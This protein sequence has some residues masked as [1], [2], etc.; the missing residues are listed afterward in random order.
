MKFLI[1][2]RHSYAASNNPAWSDHERPLTER[3]RQLAGTTAMLLADIPFDRIIH[4]DAVRTSETAQIVQAGCGHLPEL[5]PA[6]ELYLASPR[7]YLNAA[8]GVA[9]DGDTGVMV[10]GHNPGMAGLINSLSL[11]SV[12]ITPGSVAIFQLNGNDWSCL[13]NL[14]KDDAVLT[15][16]ISE[17]VLRTHESESL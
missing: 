14:E 12:P 5:F 17:G 15:T 9:G 16:F 2:M 13:R 8:A 4:S 11:Q 1:L 7:T 3:G 6:S 10:V